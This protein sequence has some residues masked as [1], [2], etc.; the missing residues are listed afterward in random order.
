MIPAHTSLARLMAETVMTLL[1]GLAGGAAFHAAG[2]PVPWLSGALTVVAALAMAGA[3]IRMPN[4]LKDLGFLVAGVSLGSTVTPEAVATIQRYP[5]S[6]IGL[7]VSV[8]A[9]VAL[10]KTILE[11]IFGWDRPTA[12]LAAV[13]GALSMVMAL[14]AESSGDVRRIAVCQAIR[15][16]T[17]VAI[18]PLL[19]TATTAPVPA[20]E[21]PV[22][23]PGGMAVMFGLTFVVAAFM[24]RF[25]FANPMF[26]GGMVTGT[27]LHVTGAIPGELPPFL[28]IAGMLMIGVFSGVRFVG[29]TPRDL[30]AIF[31][32][33]LAALSAALLVSLAFGIFVHWSTGLKLAEVLVAFAPGGVEAMIMMGAAMGLDTLYISTHHVIRSVALNLVTPFFAPGRK[34]RIG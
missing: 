28:S 9:T 32:P 3:P 14:A 19:I 26:L 27:L 15:L 6:I 23:S 2:L 4:N 20:I 17:L 13:P 25:N 29:T 30:A 33:A 7:L 31:K 10:S 8:V 21:H 16:F 22:V 18:M 11:R 5:V 1:A 34:D 12:F 24:S